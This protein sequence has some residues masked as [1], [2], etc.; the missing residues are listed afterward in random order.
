MAGASLSCPRHFSSM[1]FTFTWCLSGEVVTNTLGTPV[2]IELVAENTLRDVLTN[3]AAQIDI[4]DCKLR[5]VSECGGVSLG[6]KVRQC[7]EDVQAGKLKL[8]QIY[9]SCTSKDLKSYYID[10]HVCLKCLRE[11]GF[12]AK[13]FIDKKIRLTAAEFKGAGYTLKDLILCFPEGHHP[14]RIHPPKTNF[15]LFDCQLKDAGYEA[16]DFKDAGYSASELSEESCYY[17]E[18]FPGLTPGDIDWIEV[19][20]YFTASELASAGYSASELLAARFPES[21]VL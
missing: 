10:D 12:Q 5:F 11:L 13:D 8:Y 7:F 15:T 2:E 20:A 18:E 14:L 19:G 6:L 3:I 1:K 16:R 4:C 21:E 17:C 9:I